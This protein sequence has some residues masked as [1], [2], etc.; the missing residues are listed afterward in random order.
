M[1]MI[2]TGRNDRQSKI[3]DNANSIK[4]KY[5]LFF[6]FNSPHSLRSYLN[7]YPIILKDII[8]ITNGELSDVVFTV[9]D[10]H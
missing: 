10:N 8:F 2:F 3:P 5:T 9:T 1:A 4:M 6:N 7:G